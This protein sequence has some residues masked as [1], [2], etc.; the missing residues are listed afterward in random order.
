MA[1]FTIF[2]CGTGSN[3]YDFANTNYVAGE[4]I[5][6][7]AR[8]H[9]GHEFVDWII[10]DGPGSG[11]LQEAEKW[12]KSPNYTQTR[13]T[14]EGKGWE[15]NVK[16]A[17]A[18]LRGI[19]QDDRQEHTRKEEKLLRKMG[20]GVHEEP[21]RLWGTR[22]VQ[23]PLHARITPQMLQQKKIEILGQ[24]VTYDRINVIGWSRGGVTCHMFANAMAETIDMAHLPINIFACD[25]VPGQGNF[26]DHRIRLQKNVRNYVAVYAQDERSRGFSPVLAVL[27]PQTQSF[28]TTIPGRHAT[29]V[30]NASADGASGF[31]CLYGPGQV[32][33]DLAEKYLTS[34]GTT[35]R[36]KL[37]LS[38]VTI[39]QRYDEM[40]RQAP[41]YE[42]MHDQSYTYFT[43]SNRIINAPDGTWTD[44][45]EITQLE[46]D[47]AFVNSH[48][49]HLFRTR[50]SALYEALFERR[51]LIHRDAMQL[52]MF[53]LKMMYPNLYR[54][55]YG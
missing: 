13:G 34:W 14:L 11:N 40:L 16:H 37:D 35:L 49:R 30:G 28:I 17:V 54:R 27:Q 52:H 53:N 20:V 24:N 15:E 8:N 31:N 50:Y 42:A 41:R 12:V 45:D 2:F 4:L 46:S 19:V 18:V 22:N 5:S 44:M 55:W 36:D 32:T 38:D 47:P 51:P 48:H 21:G 33:R 6:T 39:L 25:P 1:A 9:I 23:D 10:V 7:L 43:Q 3:S 29:L 26:Q